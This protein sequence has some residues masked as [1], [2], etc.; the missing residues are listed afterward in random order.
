MQYVTTYTFKP[1]M[2]KAETKDL[3][4]AF[5]EFGNAPGTTAHYIRQDG[6]GGTVIGDTDDI[7]AL[8]RNTLNYL[9]FVEFDSHVVLPA[10]D[11]V[12]LVA[13]FAG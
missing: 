7:A 3:L 13:E 6:T 9:E 11:A 12:P 2:T 4:A 10:E 8:Y 1:F 5:A